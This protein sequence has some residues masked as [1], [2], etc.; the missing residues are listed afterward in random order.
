M[1]ELCPRRQGAG[2]MAMINARMSASP[3]PLT[4]LKWVSRYYFSTLDAMGVQDK[5][6]VRRLN[7]GVRPSIIHV[8]GS[9]KFDQQMAERKETTAEFA[10]ILDKRGKPVVLAASTHDGEEV[11]IAE[12]ASARP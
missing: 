9:I 7:P 4:A 6:D 12:A 2:I 11:L 8:T 10:A 5:G 1:A 3:E